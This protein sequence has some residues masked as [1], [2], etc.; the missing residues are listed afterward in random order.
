[1]KYLK[2]LSWFLIIGIVVVTVVPA[3]D[4]PETGFE[5]NYE[6]LLAFG[7]VGLVFALAH[8]QRLMLLLVSGV[9]SPCC[10]N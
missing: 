1:V 5:H 8:S 7:L 10:W 3:S 9:V 4:R 6:H 2:L